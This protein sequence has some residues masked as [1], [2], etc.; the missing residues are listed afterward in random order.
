VVIELPGDK[1][2]VYDAGSLG[3]PHFAV[4]SISSYL[5][6]R[7]ITR[8]D[9][10]VVSHADADHYNALPGL[11]ERFQ[12]AAVYVTPW[13]FDHSDP[14][15]DALRQALDRAEV[16]I[17]TIVRGDT[18]LPRTAARIRILHPPV[19]GGGGGDNADSI[20]LC[21]WYRGKRLLLPGD[22]EGRG[23]EMV[24][25]KRPLA[26]DVA[27][28]PHHGSPHSDPAGFA[29]WCTPKWVVISGGPSARTNEVTQSYRKRRT[30]VLHTGRHG[31]VTATIDASGLSIRSWRMTSK[32]Q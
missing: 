13:M 11:L 25:A 18:R 2:V 24:L 4:H 21:V 6:S 30:R 28:A 12:V 5:W 7:G 20:V 1:T 16:P 23:L 31:A 8:L 10:V 17:R 26:C 9:G 27:M 15:L 19:T 3:S 14:A 32:S 22:L 29:T